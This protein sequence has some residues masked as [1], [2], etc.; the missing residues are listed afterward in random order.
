MPHHGHE[1]FFATEELLVHADDRAHGLI[2]G[3]SRWRLGLSLCAI[4]HEKGAGCSLLAGDA[5]VGRP[6]VCLGGTGEHS[7]AAR[8]L[9]AGG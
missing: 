4:A 7:L 3:W 2:V 9:F 1:L 6:S 8:L 5:S